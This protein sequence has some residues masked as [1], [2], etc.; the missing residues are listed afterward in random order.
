MKSRAGRKPRNA[1]PSCVGIPSLPRTLCSCLS[2]STSPLH[3]RLSWSIRHVPA[4]RLQAMATKD[5]HLEVKHPADLGRPDAFCPQHLEPRGQR[6]GC[7]GH[8]ATWGAP[9][10]LPHTQ[11]G[12]AT[13]VLCP[14]E[15]WARE[16]RATCTLPSAQSCLSSNFHLRTK[17]RSW[18]CVQCGSRR[19]GNTPASPLRVICA[20]PSLTPCKRPGSTRQSGRKT[21]R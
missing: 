17:E 14:E 18:D 9:H 16:Q 10:R 12:T 19:Q 5:T 4:G 2:P 3:T 21:T 11:P 6:A 8:S 20:Q 15:E 13:S 7:W 1:S